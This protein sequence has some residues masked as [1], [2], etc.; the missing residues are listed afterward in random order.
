MNKKGFTVLE[1]LIVLA[2]I[3]LILAVMLA[4]FDLSRKRARDSIRVAAT[5][6]IVLAL[7][8]FRAVCRNYP[9]TL[10]LDD[11]DDP[12]YCSARSDGELAISNFLSETP[13][14]P[15]EEDVLYYAAFSTASDASRCTHYHL[16]VE[17]ERHEDEI[18]TTDSDRAANDTD[19]CL[20][21]EDDFDGHEN[22]EGEDFIYDIFK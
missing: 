4:G 5:N 22:A 2:V 13:R 11:L 16:G 9:D 6:N 17:L 7:E 20:G 14:L 15:F 19:L 21:S 12:L 8:Q 1:L 18:L 3:G 10:S